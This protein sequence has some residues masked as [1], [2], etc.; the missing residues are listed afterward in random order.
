M[1][2]LFDRTFPWTK[3]AHWA[4]FAVLLALVLAPGAARAQALSCTYSITNITFSGVDV[5]LNT[6][7]DATGT[8]NINCTGNRN[9]TVRVCPNIGS[10][11]GNPTASNPR[12]LANGANVMNYNIYSDPGL[13]TIWGSWLWPYAP[14]PPTI[15]ISLAPAGSGSASRTLYARINAG[16]QTLTALTF[17]SSFAGG[18]TNL[19]YAYTTV[20]TCSAIGGGGSGGAVPFTVTAANNKSCRVTANDLNFGAV[21]TLGSNLDVD[22]SASVTCTNA[23][24]YRVLLNNGVTG[25][26]P[27]NRK[28]TQGAYSVTYGL[29]RNSLRTQA[30]GNTSGVNSQSGTGS[31]FAQ[32]IDIYGRVPAQSVPPPGTYTDTVVMTVEY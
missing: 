21:T 20:G 23:T 5:T 2:S 18:H 24:P 26:S 31:G 25:T 13:S 14:R 12:Q 6:T 17:T 11:S 3:A 1:I 19:R 16:Q 27:T 32:T 4:A 9:R 10:G 22:G 30:W 8:L 7:F 29:Y 28:M 15:D